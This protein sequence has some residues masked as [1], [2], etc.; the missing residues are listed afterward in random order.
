V[1]NFTAKCTGMFF[2]ALVVTGCLG[3]AAL[4]DQVAYEKAINLKVDALLLMDKATQPYD[5]CKIG[6]LAFKRE[7]N[8]AWEY[9]K[10][11][12]DYSEV[13]KQYD[14]IGDSQKNLL[15]GFLARWESKGQLNSEFIKSAK[16]IVSD[17]FDMVIGL[18]S[19]LKKGK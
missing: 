1:G 16:G 10:G 7:F 12:P 19:G 8:V 3:K 5:S 17:A 18:E 14:L 6:I 13:V 15:Y 4:Y 9:V 11:L 2:I